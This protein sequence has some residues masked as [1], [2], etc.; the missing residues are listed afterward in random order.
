MST[1]GRL[2][3]WKTYQAAWSA[4]DE[5][6]RRELLAQSVAPEIVYADPGSQ[7]HGVD[8]LSTRIAASQERFPGATFCDDSFLEHHDQGLFHWTMFAGD[9]AVFA[10]GSS[11]GRFGGDGRLVQATGFFGPPTES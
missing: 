6:Q 11:F 7:T 4:V 3:T 2:K 10:T 9:G 1:T 5:T 8:E